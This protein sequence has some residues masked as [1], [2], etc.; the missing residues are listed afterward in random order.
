MINS[1][2]QR[3]RTPRMINAYKYVMDDTLGG[4]TITVAPQPVGIA[5]TELNITGVE[6]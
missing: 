4:A 6:T 2:V 5:A 3:D 1:A